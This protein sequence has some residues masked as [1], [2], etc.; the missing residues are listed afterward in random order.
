MAHYVR[1]TNEKFGRFIGELA[2]LSN[3][4]LDQH[5]PDGGRPIREVVEHVPA[6]LEGYIAEE[7]KRA[8]TD[9]ENRNE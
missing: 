9:D 4:Q 8:G 3:D 2:C 6:T 5:V 7:V 1:Q